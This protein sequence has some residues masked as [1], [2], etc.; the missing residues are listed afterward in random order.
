MFGLLVHCYL[1]S[2]FWLPVSQSV[3]FFGT[4]PGVIHIENTTRSLL[5][6]FLWKKMPLFFCLTFPNKNINFTFFAYLLSFLFY[7]FF[8]FEFYRDPRKCIK[9]DTCEF[10]TPGSKVKP[11][12][13]EHNNGWL[14][15]WMNRFLL[16]QCFVF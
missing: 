16:I 4:T 1:I 13:L 11:D 15:S 9:V 14:R 10:P 5:S 2:T 3:H 6:F 7:I 12:F 8:Y